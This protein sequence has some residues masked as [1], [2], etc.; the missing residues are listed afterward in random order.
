M[1]I[2]LIGLGNMGLPMAANL[3]KAGHAVTGYDL[4][5]DLMAK[6]VAAGGT[7]AASIA[8]AVAGAEAV[9]TTAPAACWRA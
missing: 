9:V 4:S 7:G 1:K 3:L 2:C 6:H 5:A 8:A